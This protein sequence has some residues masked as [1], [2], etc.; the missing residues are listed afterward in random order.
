MLNTGVLHTSACESII[1]SLSVIN[2]ESERHSRNIVADLLLTALIDAFSI[3]VIFLLMSFSSTGEVLFLG[4]T[5]LPKS[6]Q[7]LVLERFP[8]VRV[9]EGKL[10][11]EDKEIAGDQLTGSLLD[12]RKQYAE[13]HPGEEY[14]GIL[15]V[16]ADRRTKFE[17]LNSIVVAAGQAGFSDLKFAT[18]IK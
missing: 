15:T 10:Y 7:S 9:E 2:P 16:Q 17:L 1:G 11:L 4:K 14:P 3:L 12:L 13:G 18:V 6:A 8:V 5:E